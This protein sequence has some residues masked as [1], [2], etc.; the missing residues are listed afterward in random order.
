[1]II[2]AGMI[3]WHATCARHIWLYNYGD[4]ALRDQPSAATL[5]QLAEGVRHED[6]VLRATTPGLVPVPVR[7]WA[8]AVAQTRR[9]MAEGARVIAGAALEVTV[10]LDGIAEPVTVRGKVDRL[11]RV[12]ESLYAPVEI[13]L[14][15]KAQ[16]ADERQLDCYLWLLEQLQGAAPDGELWLGQTVDGLPARRVPHRLAPD[17]PAALLDVARLLDGSAREPELILAP[18]CKL[19]PWY[20][21]CSDDAQS[22]RHVSLLTGINRH[23]REAF[24]EAGVETMEQI[25]AMSVEQLLKFKHVGP[26]KVHAYKAQAEAYLQDRPLWYGRL[27]EVFRQPGWYFDIETDPFRGHVWSIGWGWHTDETQ[28]VVVAPT[29]PESDFALPDGRHI[30][31]VPTPH[32]AWNVFYESVKQNTQPIYHWTGF[33]AS[34]MRWQAPDIHDQLAHRLEDLHAGFK[35]AVVLPDR[36]LSLKVVAPFAG[37]HWRGY[38]DWQQAFEDY[39]RFVRSGSG[40]ALMAATAYQADDVIAMVYVWE[41]LNALAPK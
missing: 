9:L 17:F 18:H 7:D 33:D 8:D 19:C 10:T 29:A 1:M 25:R 15:G 28:V 6:D 26:K 40:E 22:R 20:T 21:L 2:T 32:A 38:A 34:N 24:A 4:P 36:S 16:P 12:G 13:K 11:M 27:A 3:R 5:R 37:F 30:T 31:L 41:M 23:T 35:G 14:A 39:Q